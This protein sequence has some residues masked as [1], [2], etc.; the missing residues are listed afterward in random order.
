MKLKNI[1]AGFIATA[2]A[3]STFPG[4][5]MAASSTMTI[6]VDTVVKDTVDIG[7]SSDYAVANPV[8]KDGKIN[9]SFIRTFNNFKMPLVR[10]G[11]GVTS[12]FEWKE[13]VG[14]LEDRI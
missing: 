8:Y 6:D 11:E 7:I 10:I 4:S 12:S 3:L 13:A 5:V 9:S 1:L 2:L 14:N